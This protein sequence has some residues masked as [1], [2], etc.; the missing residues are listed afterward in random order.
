MPLNLKFRTCLITLILLVSSLSI[1]V[2]T[3]INVKALE[4]TGETLYFT[5]YNLSMDFEEYP[6]M[7]TVPPEGKNYS[8]FP[9]TIKNPE[10]WLEWFGLWI[11]SRTLDL[12]EYLGM[13]VTELQELLDEMGMTLDELF[14]YFELFNPFEMK[15]IYIYKGE[16]KHVSGD[17]VFDLYFSSTLSS[18]L[19]FKDKVKV[20]FY[21]NGVQQGNDTI[22]TIDSNL[23]QDKIQ[24]QTIFIEGLDFDLEN[25]DELIF[26]IEM[27]PGSKPIGSIFESTD[28]ETIINTAD[29]IADVL[30]N[31]SIIPSLNNIGEALKEIV[32]LSQEEEFS[33]TT[34]DLADLA[35]TVRSSSFIYNSAS[36]KSSV[37]IP[38]EISEEE[39]IVTYYLRDG[40]ELKEEKPTKE[41]SSK[42]GLKE[43]KKWTSPPLTRSKILKEATATLYLSYRDLIRLLNL[44]KT[45][46]VASLKYDDTLISKSE[47]DLKKTTILKKLL[48]PISQADF[49][50]IFDEPIEIDH[51]NALVLEVSVA[52]GTKFR[53][54]GLYRD[55]KLVYDSVDYPSNLFLKFDETSNIKSVLKTER[56]QKIVTGGSAKYILNISS[57]FDDTITFNYFIKEKEGEWEIDTPDPIGITSGETVLANIF[58]NHTDETIDAYN[59]DLIDLYLLPTGKTGRV[60]EDVKIEVSE[61]AIE[62]DLDIIAPSRKEI[63]HGT[64]D[65]YTFI[66]TNNKTGL[67]P[68][69]YEIEAY[70]EHDWN[71][72]LTYDED[73]INDVDV[74][75]EFTVQIKLFVP[76]YTDICNELLTL[77]LISLES[78]D[79]E[80][81]KII[82]VNVTTN[83]IL[84]NIFE[85]IYH[86]FES[87]S[88]SL[89]LNSV[90]GDYGG[91]FLIFITIFLLVF[92]LT[93]ILFFVR[94]KYIDI[95]CFERIKEINPDEKAE[96][97]I[98][99][100]NPSRQKLSYEISAN[101]NPTSDRWDIYLDKTTISLEPKE[102]EQIRL[103]VKP[104][105]FAKSGDWAE[106]KV[107]AKTVEKRKIAKISTMTIL[108]DI[109]PKLEI[110]GVLNWPKV[111]NKGDLVKTSF[112]VENSGKVSANNVSIILYINGKEKNKVEDITI[113]R[114]GYADIE[115][116][117]IAEKGKNEINIVV[118]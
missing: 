71:L 117:W 75:E 2:V 66:I 64:S 50:F 7:S 46:I 48:R 34:D 40:G 24:E 36:Y 115:M 99:I 5:K 43:L 4:G 21:I 61:D 23:F 37:T 85:H 10:E 69:S 90:I 27:Q 42:A 29:L 9:P 113:P 108:K 47:V 56:E 22:V 59:R 81:E 118:K 103:I 96:F 57:K 30:I 41:K 97:D 3:P 74:G 55:V 38:T 116:P 83:I 111:F 16:K 79:H 77:K 88:E 32:N 105:D 107:E 63:K 54:F 89:G 28:I 93:I 18:K 25:N 35:N 76:A 78:Q 84:P 51:D 94:I 33:F 70:T 20:A 82:Y 45:K 98:T 49:E 26:S 13:N 1:F 109:K 114:G 60:K 31:Q 72:E 6:E 110:I 8:S 101:I 91:W 73:K 95:I 102:S 65:T 17:V 58:V 19:M 14:E 62:F 112:K 80:K 106:V 68:D 53:L 87:A 11:A 92:F 100:Q 86:S 12:E 67:W 104:T 52:N 15:E 44:G 39:N